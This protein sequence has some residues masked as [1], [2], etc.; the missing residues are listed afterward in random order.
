MYALLGRETA[1]PW[2]V[3]PLR[4]G[5]LSRDVTEAFIESVGMH[6]LVSFW[7]RGVRFKAHSSTVYEL[8]TVQ[9]CLL[10]HRF[11]GGCIL[12][13]S[14]RLYTSRVSYRSGRIS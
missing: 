4:S 13:T 8:L 10:P 3:L 2:Y 6:W 9:S 12:S 11:V 1:R 5:A 14:Y 7:S